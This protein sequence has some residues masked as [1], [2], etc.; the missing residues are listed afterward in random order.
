MAT[1]LQLF[2]GLHGTLHI[3]S[4]LWIVVLYAGAVEVYG[5]GICLVHSLLIVSCDDG[6]GS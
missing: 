4:Y 6:I 5:D 3:K 1:A 2:E